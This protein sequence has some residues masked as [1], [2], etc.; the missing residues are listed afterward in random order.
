[1]MSRNP[2]IDVDVAII[3]AGPSGLYAAYYAGFRG[4][5]TALIDSLPAA[6]GQIAAMYPEKAIY[7]VAGFPS[8]KGQ[9]L[10]DGLYQQA[11]QWGPELLL[12]SQCEDLE[13][14]SDDV[15]VS[16][17]DG[18]RVRAK[19]LLITAGIGTFEPRQL[20]TGNEFE[21]RGLRYFVPK[22]D[23]L[24]DQD[25]VI[26]GGGDS[27]VDWA[28]ALE[29]VASSVTLL[30]RRDRFRAHERSVQQLKDSTVNVL[31]PYEVSE[32]HGA[33]QLE[34][35]VTVSKDGDAK[36][37]PAQTL[38]AALGF[39]ADLGPLEMWGLELDRRSIVVDRSMRTNVERVFAAGDVNH[40]EGKVKL[41]SVGF[42]EA[43]LAIN[44]MAQLV[45]P[46][47]GLNPGHSTDI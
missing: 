39:I 10:V 24:R 29:N 23:E 27:A 32:L 18:R 7:D 34:K 41:I 4:L 38:V 42:G 17:H 2:V 47:V 37:L 26:A 46:D 19:A 1:M 43:A 20:P 15:T 21:G 22:L 12:D 45:N 40:F 9:D 36:H 30:H 14:S 11:M 16:L 31:T 13:Q 33:G 6:G 5:T 3:G 25:V 35:V 28:L 44:H 8:I